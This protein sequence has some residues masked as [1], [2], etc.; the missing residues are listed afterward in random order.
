LR[1]AASQRGVAVAKIDVQDDE[2]GG[3]RR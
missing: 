3:G 1:Q 2:P